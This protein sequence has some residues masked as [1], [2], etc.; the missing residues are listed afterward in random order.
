MKIIFDYQ[1][2]S[3]QKHGGISRYFCNLIKEIGPEARLPI[4]KHQNE[5]L[6]KEPEIVDLQIGKKSHLNFFK[7][8]PDQNKEVTKK[9]LNSGDFDIFHATYYDNYFLESLGRKPFV[10][11]IHDMIYE[12]FPEMFSLKD[13]LTI[14]KKELAQKADKIIVVSEQTKKD[15]LKFI[16][17]KEE[18]IAVIYQ[19]CSLDE[20]L[21]KSVEVQ[22]PQK[23]FLLFVGNRSIYK[24]F[25]FMLSA[26][27]EV[28]QNNPNL[29]LLCFGALFDK[30]ENRFIENLGLEKKV[31][32]VSGGDRELVSLY[33]SALA[34]ISPS[35][36]EGFGVTILESFACGCPVL[37]AKASATTEAAGNAALY[38]DPKDPQATKSAVE[39]IISDS[40]L[41]AD[42]VANGYEQNKKFSWQKA[43]TEMKQVYQTIL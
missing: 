19:A 22:K 5:Y 34:F 28:L 2:F 11:T 33:K 6:I 18:K 16:D 21:I 13:R 39:K 32:V 25:Y 20:S 26:I 15:L 30:K 27:S 23:E 31:R 42:L 43:A 10:I 24:N 4:Q 1:I 29:E 40:A 8:S 14:L 9:I 37:A 41:R 12:L 3:A 17:I 35:Y 36:Y 38:F 7:K